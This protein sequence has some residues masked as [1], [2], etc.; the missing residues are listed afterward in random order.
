M[1]PTLQEFQG[2]GQNADSVRLQVA[3]PGTAVDERH[4]EVATPERVLKA[5]GAIFVS[6]CE[7][8]M[9]RERREEERAERREPL[10]RICIH[11]SPLTNKKE[12]NISV[13]I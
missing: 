8:G 9:K 3:L 11:H 13:P 12:K 2:Y 7:G 6:K 5:A 10:N 1:V 4:S